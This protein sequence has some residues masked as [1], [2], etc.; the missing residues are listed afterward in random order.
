[1]NFNKL[2][3]G[4]AAVLSLAAC[5]K[6]NDNKATS[7][8]AQVSAPASVNAADTYVAGT[9]NYTFSVASGTLSADGVAI[10]KVDD[11]T[12]AGYPML[13]S[14]VAEL[15][16]TNRVIE[17][18]ENSLELWNS[19]S[20]LLAFDLRSGAPTLLHSRS[21][22]FAIDSATWAMSAQ[23]K[24]QSQGLSSGDLVINMHECQ[25]EQKQEQGKEQGQ[26]Q[27][28]VAPIDQGKS[29]GQDQGKAMPAPAPIDQGKDQGKPSDQGQNQGKK[30]LASD[31]VVGGPSDQGQGQNQGK[32]EGKPAQQCKAVVMTFHVVE[33]AQPKQDQGKDQGK[34]QGQ[35]QGKGQDQGKTPAPI[36]QGKGQDQG[37]VAPA[38]APIDQGKGQDQG[39]TPAPIDQGKGQDQ[40]KVAPAP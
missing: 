5:S 26:D 39:K 15:S 36:D 21:G 32:E 9:P 4:A 14:Q 27:G 19:D 37:K 8:S 25:V 3:I 38:P 40:G 31:L 29:Q 23:D 2:L 10:N 11:T 24:G 12:F 16:T 13:A 34:D 18:K 28:K 22:N 30:F 1:M 17:T 6:S 33:I 20:L 7:G 35:N